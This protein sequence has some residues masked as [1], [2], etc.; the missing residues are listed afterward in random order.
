MSHTVIF[1]RA[2]TDE[3]FCVISEVGKHHSNVFVA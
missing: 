3:T 1:K 2:D